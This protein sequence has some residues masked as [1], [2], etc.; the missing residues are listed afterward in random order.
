MNQLLD[1]AAEEF[2]TMGVA[3]EA[4]GYGVKKK[5]FHNVPKSM[6][7][8]WIYPTPG[9]TNPEQYFKS[10]NWIRSLAAGPRPAPVRAGRSGPFCIRATARSRTQ[11]HIM[12]DRLVLAMGNLPFS[13]DHWDRLEA[14]GRRPTVWSSLTR[15]TR[16]G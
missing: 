6:P 13:A 12:T 3:F 2:W 16:P 15:T 9:P 1:I 14:G 8:S 10:A 7:A 11:S 5:N 4:N